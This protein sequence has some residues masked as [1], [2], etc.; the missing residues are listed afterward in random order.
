M[1]EQM[2]G[3]CESKAMEMSQYNQKY[4][5]MLILTDGAIMDLDKTIDQ[6]VRA[7]D[8][9]VSIVVIG[10]GRADFATMEAL[11]ADLEPLH[12]NRFNKGASRDCVQF[13]EFEHYKNDP[14]GLAKEV[15]K[16]IPKQMI[17]YFNKMKIKPN[18]ATP[19][20]RA[21]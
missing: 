17:A 21:A 16:E 18:D 2:N 7:S 11:D 19:E 6:V 13:V 9:P 20:V 10:V 1:L 15:L 12:S 8:L 3:Y 5:I 4:N 14:I